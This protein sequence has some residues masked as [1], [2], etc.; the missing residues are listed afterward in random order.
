M[1]KLFN[2][3]LTFGQNVQQENVAFNLDGMF[4][5]PGDEICALKF[6]SLIMLLQMENQQFGIPQSEGCHFKAG[7]MGQQ[8]LLTVSGLGLTNVFKTNFIFQF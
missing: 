8:R 6:L 3:D 5:L 2:P 4:T 7:K 1:A